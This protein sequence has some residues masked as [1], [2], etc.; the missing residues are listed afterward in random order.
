MKEA[1]V[2]QTVRLF[3]TGAPVGKVVEVYDTG[4]VRVKWGFMKD[5]LHRTSELRSVSGPEV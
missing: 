5:T 2:G 4:W 1:K 3:N